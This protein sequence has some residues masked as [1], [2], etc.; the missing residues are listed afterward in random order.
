MLADYHIR[1]RQTFGSYA[2]E[3]APDSL[4]DQSLTFAVPGVETTA[5]GEARMAPT[6]P[7]PPV[8]LE[9]YLPRDRQLLR[10]LLLRSYDSRSGYVHVGS[11]D[12]DLGDQLAALIH[13]AQDRQPLPFVGLRMLLRSL[14]LHELEAHG[15]VGALP[16]FQLRH[17]PS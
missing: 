12:V 14:I 13:G 7:E 15:Q 8:P 9:Q 11:R 17:Q 1:L 10:K 3:V 4:W 6:S 5:T 2:S 16:G